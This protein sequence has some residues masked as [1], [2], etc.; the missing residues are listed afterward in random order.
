MTL[1]KEPRKTNRDGWR[2]TQNYERS[3]EGIKKLTY[4]R[5]SFN[6]IAPL[7]EYEQR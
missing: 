6:S 5:L 1:E 2:K 7:V 3:I 4:F